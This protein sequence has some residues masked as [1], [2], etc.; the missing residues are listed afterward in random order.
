MLPLGGFGDITGDEGLGGNYANFD[1]FP[2]KLDPQG[3]MAYNIY[4]TTPSAATTCLR[5]TLSAMYSLSNFRL[6]FAPVFLG[7]T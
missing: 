4:T 5:Y 2:P 6:A 7:T 1:K 3:D